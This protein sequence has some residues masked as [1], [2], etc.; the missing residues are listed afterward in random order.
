MIHD[1]PS[2]D[3]ERVVHHVLVDLNFGDVLRRTHV[4]PLPGSLVVVHDHGSHR[5][6]RLFTGE[7][8]TTTW[9]E[10]INWCNKI[11]VDNRSTTSL[12]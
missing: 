10:C 3:T 5:H 2:D 7:H 8:Q 12:N 6:R 4:L 9:V 11:A 1:P